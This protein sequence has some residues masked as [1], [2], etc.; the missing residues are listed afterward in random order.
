MKTYLHQDK[1]VSKAAAFTKVLNETEY[2]SVLDPNG[3][4][5]YLC[6]IDIYFGGEPA[7]SVNIYY[8]PNKDTYK[9]TA[10]SLP[11]PLHREKISNYWQQF[12]EDA[13]LNCKKDHICAYVDGS[14]LGGKTGYGAVIIKNDTILHEI[15]GKLDDTYNRHHQIG[16]ELK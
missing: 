8:S 7:G 12:I 5:D 1:T 6:K 15:S 4:R 2:T 10:Q 16:G 13:S 14:F 11:D 3:I 9:L